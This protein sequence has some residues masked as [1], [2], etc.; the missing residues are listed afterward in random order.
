MTTPRPK[1]V[2]GTMTFG[3][4]SGGRISD[5]GE[6]KEILQVFASNGFNE[7]DT[8]RMYCDGNTGQFS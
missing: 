3:E 7:L 2:F 8:A 1:V 5:R 6:M 4:G